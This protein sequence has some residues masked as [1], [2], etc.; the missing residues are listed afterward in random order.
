M[1]RVYY[2]YYCVSTVSADFTIYILGRSFAVP[3]G[4]YTKHAACEVLLRSSSTVTITAYSQVSNTPGWGVALMKE[5]LP[6]SSMPGRGF[7]LMTLHA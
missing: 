1:Q 6:N 2:L 4:A 7:E 5:D 3:Q